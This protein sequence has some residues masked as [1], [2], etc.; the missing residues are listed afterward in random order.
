LAP[1]YLEE[2][3][4]GRRLLPLGL[5]VSDFLDVLVDPDYVEGAEAA[6]CEAL[7]QSARTW[8]FWSAEEA[9]ATAAVLSLTAPRS[10]SS[11]I[12]RQSACPVLVLPRSVEALVQAIPARKMRKWRM[13]QNRTSRRAWQFER[14]TEETL[15]D[16]LDHLF[17]LH[18]ARWQSRGEAGVLAD[19]RIRRFHRAAAPGLLRAGL[20]R[21]R[22][23]R[24]DGQVAGIYHGF[25]QSH[26]AYAYLSG[27][28][29]AFA[30]ESPGTVLIGSAIEEAVAEGAAEFHLLRGQEPYKYEWGAVDRW[31]SRRTLRVGPS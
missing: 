27:F 30:F 3:T 29:P 9:P 10:W 22:A 26:R 14:A 13:A 24:I 8:D 21:L 12:E 23:L 28:D 20:L 7:T 19:D 16:L 11:H 25:Q 17:R 15:G 18:G 1:L 4:W 31:N 5:G 2:G 6:V